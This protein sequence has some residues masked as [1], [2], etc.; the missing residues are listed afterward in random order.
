MLKVSE[1]TDEKL[2]EYRALKE[3]VSKW[4]YFISVNK[5]EKTETGYD[6]AVERLVKFEKENG[7]R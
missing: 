1:L 2:H 7:I 3:I 4:S 6:K 5:N